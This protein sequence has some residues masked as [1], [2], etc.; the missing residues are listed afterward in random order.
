ML[1]YKKL[2]IPIIGKGFGFLFD[3]L[4]ES[5]LDSI[6]SNLKSL[7][8]AHVKL[9]LVVEE[10]ILLM[11]TTR[12]QVNENRRSINQISDRYYH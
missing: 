2:F 6:R 4:S 10:N 11:K 3:T 1:K 8:I 5:D 9:Q 7:A 12:R